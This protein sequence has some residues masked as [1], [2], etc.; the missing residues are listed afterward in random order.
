MKT[1]FNLLTA[2]AAALPIAWIDNGMIANYCPLIKTVFLQC[3]KEKKLLILK[4]ALQMITCA[5]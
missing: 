1:K 3:D 5:Q 2:Y 4:G